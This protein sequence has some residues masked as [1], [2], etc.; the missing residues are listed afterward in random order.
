[1]ASDPSPE[2][3]RQ[4]THDT[5]IQAVENNYAVVRQCDTIVLSI[6]P[7]QCDQVLPEVADDVDTSKLFVSIMA[8]VPTAHINKLLG[9]HVRVVRAMPNMPLLVGFGMTALCRGKHAWEADLDLAGKLFGCG[10]QVVELTETLMD[11][12][13]ATSGSGP[14]YFAAFA[15]AVIDAG[16]QGGLSPTDARLLVGHTMLGT[17]K[18]LLETDQNLNDLV[19]R[20]SSPGG[21]TEAAFNVFKAADVLKAIADGTRAAQQRSAEM[22]KARKK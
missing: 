7:Q 12:V 22:G 3:R 6:K 4:F 11:A 19:R 8:G 16:V 13:T 10:G 14:A 17:A 18:I 2:Q 9:G 15:Q 20:V 5:G 1:M 21:T